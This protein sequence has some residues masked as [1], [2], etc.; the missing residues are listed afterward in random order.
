MV[1]AP[2]NEGQKAP[3]RARAVNAVAAEWVAAGLDGALDPP[4]Q[5]MLDAW[6][7]AD[8]AHHKAYA[9]M[10]VLWRDLDAIPAQAR[11]VALSDDDSVHTSRGA[12]FPW[13]GVA[14]GRRTPRQLGGT[15][16]LVLGVLTLFIVGYA[17]NWPLRLQADAMT[18][19][20]ERRLISLADGSRVRL[21]TDSAIAVDYSADSRRIRLLQGEAIFTVAPDAARPFVV[22]ASRGEIRALGTEFVVHNNGNRGDVAVTE[23]SVAVRYPRARDVTVHAGQ[24]VSFTPQTGLGAVHQADVASA[25]AWVDGF[26]VVKDMP[27]EQLVTEIGRYRSGY[28]RVVGSARRTRVSGVFRIDQ[29]DHALMQLERSLALR[30]TRFTDK[31]ILIH[32]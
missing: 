31:F 9:E 14:F 16:L 11:R 17:Q 5:D 32:Q 23:H 24:S 22:A 7:A 10:M 27:L 12:R 19:V 8:P 26:L 18:A 3:A 1:G 25:T 21:N 15:R 28:V 30:S 6:L 4:S 29:P 20:G 2:E 13:R